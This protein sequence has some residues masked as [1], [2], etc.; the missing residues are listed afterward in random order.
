MLTKENDSRHLQEGQQG[1][2]KVFLLTEG[3]I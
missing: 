2:L 1:G 3:V